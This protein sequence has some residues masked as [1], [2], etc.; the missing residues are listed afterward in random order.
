MPNPNPELIITEIE[1]CV[2]WM[3]TCIDLGR[4]IRTQCDLP[5][6]APLLEAVCI[7]PDAH[8]HQCIRSMESYVV[9]ELNVR[10]LVVTSDKD[11]YGVQL[12]G[13]LN[14]K[15]LGKRLQKHYKPVVDAIQSIS[16]AELEQFTREGKIVIAGQELSGD[17]LTVVYTTSSSAAEAA[18]GKDQKKALNLYEAAS[19]R[20]MLLLLNTSKCDDLEEERLARE[21]IN[22]IQR[23][24]RKANLVPEQPIAIA[25][26]TDSSEVKSATE[27]LS[28]LIQLTVKQPICVCT[29][30]EDP[31]QVTEKCVT[32]SIGGQVIVEETSITPYELQVIIYHRKGAT[33][34]S[35]DMHSRVP[36]FD[37]GHGHAAPHLVPLWDFEEA[38]SKKACAHVK[39][40][41][42]GRKPVLVL[43]EN[44]KNNRLITDVNDLLREVRALFGWQQ[45]AGLQLFEQNGSAPLDNLNQPNVFAL[46]GST[47]NAK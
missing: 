33:S 16:N 10:K 26:K 18:S 6:K 45:C 43:L 12:K 29:C 7:H 32:D 8:V 38:V 39:V 37:E 25:I 47:L 22:R 21:L 27:K 13:V 30:Q 31:L 36:T 15:V 11:Q 41:H 42:Q 40:V 28:D 2:A 3:Q 5:L 1:E 19:D 34:S 35:L 17:D 20:G 14:H 4:L 44:P 24:R 9:E 23:T 46:N